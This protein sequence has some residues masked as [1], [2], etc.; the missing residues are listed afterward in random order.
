MLFIIIHNISAFNYLSLFGG[1]MN[2][3]WLSFIYHSSINS[4]MVILIQN[5]KLSFEMCTSYL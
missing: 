3:M 5:I 4:N 2:V 1:F